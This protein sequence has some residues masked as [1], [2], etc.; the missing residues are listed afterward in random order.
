MDIGFLLDQIDNFLYFPVLIIVMALAGFY[1]SFKTKGVQIRLFPESL[2]I[3]LEPSGD[4]N[5]SSAQAMLVSTAS[6]VGTGNIIGVSTAIC[7]GGPGACFWMWIMCIIGASSAFIE[8]TL[9]QIYKRKDKDGNFYGGPAYYIEQGLK[10]P[11]LAAVFCVCLIVTYAVGFNLLCS[12]N[13]QSTFLEYSF[14]NPSTTPY[15]IGILLAILV[16]YCLL[17]GGKRIVRITS[18]VVP[19]MGI[20][21]VIVAVIVILLNYQ[22]VPAMFMLILR[23]A[24]NFQA[25]AGGFAGSCLVYG[26]KRGLFSNEAGVGSAP[27]ASASADVSHPA[28]QGLVQTLSVYIDTLLL[29]TAT[30][31]MCLSTGVARDVSVSGAP[32][33]QNAISSVF[34]MAGPLFITVAMV[35]F[36]FT[37]L[38][39]NL[40]YV[41]NAIIYLNHK[42]NPSKTFMRI[43]YIGATFI[44]FLGA[45]IPMDTAWA[46]ADITMGA[47]TLINLPTC[48]ALGK[49]AIA[50]LKD[51][52]QQKRNG[53]NPVFKASS[54]GMNAEELDSWK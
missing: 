38:L 20:S 33:V 22:N 15:I 23:D 28:K 34:G 5:V 31:L 19:F 37:T 11:K 36:A 2:R 1:F 17:G 49:T 4:G 10:K 6:R 46:M 43:F 13:L 3:L 26:I 52:E 27:N 39:G 9:A 16:G 14:Y 21:Y 30:A 54:I 25:I 45:I 8:S 12:Y 24:F 44:V 53:Q 48:M 7:L 18:T 29:C 40:F 32:Y 41:D 42:K 47:M 50:C 51:Y 35:L